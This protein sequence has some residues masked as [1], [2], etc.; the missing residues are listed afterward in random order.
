MPNLQLPELR[1]HENVTIPEWARIVGVKKS[2]GYE[3]S[4]RNAIPGM[5]RVGKFVRVNLP[6][7]YAK[8]GIEQLP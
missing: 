1:A 6:T 4:R 3:L 5:F 7:Y 2:Y 8:S